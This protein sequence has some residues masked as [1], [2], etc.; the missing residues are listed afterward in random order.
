MLGTVV[1]QVFVSWCQVVAE[2]FLGV[3][4]SEPP[5][6]HV[7]GLDHFVQ[8][9][10]LCRYYSH[11]VDIS[12]FRGY[13]PHL[14]DI[15]CIDHITINLAFNVHHIL[16]SFVLVVD[17]IFIDHIMSYLARNIGPIFHIYLLSERD[18]YITFFP[19]CNLIFFSAPFSF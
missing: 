7:H 13:Y 11:F 4:T 9:Y 14:L 12:A 2:V 1:G 10:T 16:L 3:G 8:I 6:A 18:W 19:V 17:I 5:E 15:I